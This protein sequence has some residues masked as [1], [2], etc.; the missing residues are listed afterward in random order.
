MTDIHKEIRV[1][2]A[3]ENAPY[4]ERAKREQ[5]SITFKASDGCEVTVTPDGQV[6]FNISDWW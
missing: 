5:R 3:R 2:E 6:F 4:I 1:H